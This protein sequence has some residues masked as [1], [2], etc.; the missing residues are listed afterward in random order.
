MR[1]IGRLLR[2]FSDIQDWVDRRVK[3]SRCLVGEGSVL[4]PA[5]IIINNRE[6]HNIRI[7]REARI[8]GRLTT[9]G[10]GGD[11]EIGE[12]CYIGERSNIWSAE[13]IKIG[14]RVLVSHDV[15]I[16]DNNSHSLSAKERH[17]HFVEMF[18]RGH[19][20]SLPGVTSAPVVIGDD[21]WIGFGAAIFKGVTVGRGAV[22]AARSVVTKDVPPYTVVA[23][24][25]AQ[26]IKKIPVD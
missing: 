25:P 7:G 24:F 1:I 15:E 6:R 22:I 12:Y 21:C 4:Y 23:G 9:Y 17:Q 10:H 19:P 16:H 8:L 26:V 13:S 20:R 14:N 2:P 11:I 5:S 3:L 18:S